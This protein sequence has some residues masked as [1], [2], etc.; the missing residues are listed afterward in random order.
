MT[1]RQGSEHTGRP[2]NDPECGE[3]FQIKSIPIG[4]YLPTEWA[5]NGT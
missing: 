4:K 3:Y 2:T 1:Q 5:D